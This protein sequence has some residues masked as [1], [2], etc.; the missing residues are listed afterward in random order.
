[1][2]SGLKVAIREAALWFLSAFAVFSVVFFYEEISSF[3]KSKDVTSVAIAAKE[4]VTGTPST[5]TQH[6]TGTSGFDRI[7]TLR[8]NRGG[9]FYTD[10]HINF[11]QIPVVVD[12]GA[13]LVSLNYDHAKQIGLRLTKSDFKYRTRTANG[14]SNIARVTLD[15]VRI[16]DI[17]VRNVEASV[18]E[19]GKMDVTLLGMSFL[20]KV[21]NINLANGKLI[22]TN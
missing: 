18:A 6:D 15:T 3:I 8:A 5:K 11:R 19:P 1:M 10:A 14:I 4:A 12:T 17:E 9:H 2:S 22:L 21:K 20:G 7:V 13:T 16:G